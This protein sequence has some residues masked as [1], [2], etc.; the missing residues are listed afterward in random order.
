MD[1][2]RKK[3]F[4]ISILSGCK[5]G[6]PTVT[7]IVIGHR[8]DYCNILFKSVNLNVKVSFKK[9]LPD[10]NFVYRLSLWAI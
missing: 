8:Y 7:S 6:E 1:H 3:F 5:R 2:T 9:N 4:N 10:R